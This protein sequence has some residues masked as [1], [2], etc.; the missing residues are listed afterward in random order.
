MVIP[1]LIFSYF[2]S[3]LRI[4]GLRASLLAAVILFVTAPGTHAQVGGLM[5]AP[6]RITLSGD[7][8]NSEV[9]V[10]NTS[11]RPITARI[12][13]VNRRMLSDGTFTTPEKPLA[14][15]H[16]AENHIRFAPRR[17]ILQPGQGQVV[18]ILGQRPPGAA[19]EYR[20]HMLFRVEPEQRALDDGPR[21]R[22][23]SNKGDKVSIRLQPVYGVS[24][25]LILRA[26]N[27]SASASIENLDVSS[28]GT[29]QSSVSFDIRR[30]GNRSIYGDIHVYNGGD[31][32]AERLVAKIRGVAVYTPL[33]KR[34]V[35]IPLAQYNRE[36]LDGRLRVEFLDR[37]TSDSLLAESTTSL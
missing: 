3:A 9:Y 36:D 18:R 30:H 4:I 8:L 35:V 5:V 24:I 21:N 10:T 20:S 14:G 19:A 6:T 17:V 32:K 7:D 25:P 23:A 12:T 15:E 27:L 34:H 11:S 29:G 33:E 22:Q 16:F 28:G 37:D 26:G 13:L 31:G 2:G 1:L